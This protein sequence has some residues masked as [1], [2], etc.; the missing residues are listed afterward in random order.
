MDLARLHP[1]ILLDRS[2]AQSLPGGDML[3]GP[4]EAE[5]PPH[6]FPC[7]M[8]GRHLRKGVW[9]FISGHGVPML[10]NAGA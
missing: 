3:A 8:H 10:W 5:G 2:T 9:E 1:A 6:V 7:E 4:V